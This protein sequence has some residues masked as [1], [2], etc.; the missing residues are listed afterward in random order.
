MLW[1]DSWRHYVFGI[2]FIIIKVE[3]VFVFAYIYIFA[4]ER[5]HLL[6]ANF[7]YSATITLF[8]MSLGPSVICASIRNYLEVLLYSFAIVSQ[9]KHINSSLNRVFFSQMHMCFV[10]FISSLKMAS[11]WKTTI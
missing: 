6:V 9:F 4:C 7:N 1:H 2:K 8:R 5:Y 3:N 11:P 10:S